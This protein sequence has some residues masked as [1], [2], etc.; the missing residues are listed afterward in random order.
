M[1]Y[2][3]FFFSVF[4]SVSVSVLTFS[5]AGRFLGDGQLAFIAGLLLGPLEQ[6]FQFYILSW[7]SL[8]PKR[9][10]KSINTAK[11][12]TAFQLIDRG[13]CLKHAHNQLLDTKDLFVVTHICFEI[14]NALSAD[15]NSIDKSIHVDVDVVRYEFK[16]KHVIEMIWTPGPINLPGLGTETNSSST[17][18]LLQGMAKEIIAINLTGFEI[19]RSD[20]SLG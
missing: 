16:T 2:V 8:N 19:R 9:S 11:I 20:L 10:V 17:Q 18:A 14:P 3:W 6:G 15:S 7:S 12:L 4:V 13:I 1:Y 5:D